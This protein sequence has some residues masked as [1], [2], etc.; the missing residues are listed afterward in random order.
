MK[1]RRISIENFLSLGDV[2]LDIDVFKP[3]LVLIQGQ[4]E[5]EPYFVSNAAGKTSLIEALVWCLYGEPIRRAKIA[6]V[7]GWHAKS[8]S[9]TV[10][11]LLDGK[12]LKITRRRSKST[13]LHV[14]YDGKVLDRHILA[15]TEQVLRDL[16]GVDYDQFIQTVVLEG[17][18]IGRFSYLTDVGRKQLVEELIGSRLWERAYKETLARIRSN[19][20]QRDQ[21]DRDITHLKDLAIQE[22]ERV[23]SAIEKMAATG[24]EDLGELKG[25]VNEAKKELAREKDSLTELAKKR[26]LAVGKREEFEKAVEVEEE[27]GRELD[28]RIALLRSERDRLL[29][30]IENKECPTCG[31][32]VKIGKFKTTLTAV[33]LDLSDLLGDQEI[34]SSVREE[35]I[36]RV[37][38]A[39][40]VVEKI[41]SESYEKET[42][43]RLLQSQ[44]DQGLKKLN[45][46]K[47]VEKVDVKDKLLHESEEKVAEYQDKVNRLGKKVKA[48]QSEKEI[49][50][51]WRSTFP[52]IRADSLQSVLEFLNARLLHY[53]S[54]LSDGSE[55]VQIELKKDKI[56]LVTKIPTRT[57]RHPVRSSGERRRSDLSI[58]FALGDLAG[59]LSG[60]QPSLLIVDECLDTLDP[61][62]TR[63]V[64][65]VLE[66]LARTRSVWITTHSPDVRDELEPDTCLLVRKS[67]GISRV[68][69]A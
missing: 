37:H 65:L 57:S 47:K 54:I 52:S 51:Y 64:L 16:I 10:E 60:T 55:I 49:L 8:C 39:E 1:F 38:D 63:R 33:E 4:N 62:A 6:E 5:D 41:R 50:L 48:L 28:Q 46:T 27:N 29:E 35:L 20:S 45:Q 36:K 11:G 18:L 34:W 15:E 43:V 67:N 7:V 68:E 40:N 44:I 22:R 32:K 24:S 31:Q 19:E 17:G 23:Q 9:V 13:H 30:L 2:V 69:A 21:V 14:E 26:R 12:L 25:L 42:S 66:E 3:G 56:D 58:Q 53:G 61:L 59:T